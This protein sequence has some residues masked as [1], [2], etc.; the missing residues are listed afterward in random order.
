MFIGKRLLYLELPKT[1]CS[2]VRKLLVKLPSCHGRKLGKH[3]TIYRLS[4][5][6]L[7]TLPEKIK[8]GNIRNPWDWYVSLWAFGC[9]GRGL[10]H[11]VLTKKRDP[12]EARHSVVEW[13]EVYHELRPELFRRWLQML[14]VTHRADVGHGFHRNEISR[15]VGFLTHRYLKLYTVRVDPGLAS[16]QN[17]QQLK[18]FDEQQNLL[19]FF[20]RTEHIAEDLLSILSAIPITEPEQHLILRL[21][22]SRTNSSV[23]SRD[24]REYYDGPTAEL[25]ANHD[26]YLIRKHGYQFDP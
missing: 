6:E 10:V 20:V 21:S 13:R 7:S 9:M 17:R 24:F 16:I 5:E 8:F 18:N 12:A 25:V 22:Q 1:G 4:P 11:R 19:D 14:L 3:N 2:H 15:S 26:D 23:R